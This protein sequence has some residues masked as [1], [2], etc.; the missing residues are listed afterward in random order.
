LDIFSYEIVIIPRDA[1]GGVRIL[2]KNKEKYNTDY[3]AQELLLN[4]ILGKEYNDNDKKRKKLA[5]WLESY[6]INLKNI[7]RVLDVQIKVVDASQFNSAS[8][9]PQII[10]INVI[11]LTN[12][13]KKTPSVYYA[14]KI[15]MMKIVE[16][17]YTVKSATDGVTIK[18]V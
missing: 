17:G 11:N 9:V 7:E 8:L 3:I 6:V 10:T 5:N 2:N 1:G 13:K 15:N 14:L 12:I 18:N 4:I 16:T